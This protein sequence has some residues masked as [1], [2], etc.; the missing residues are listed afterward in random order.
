MADALGL[1][2]VDT[3]AWHRANVPGVNDVWRRQT[4]ANRVAV[5]APAR[6]E[7]L[8]SAKSADDY[9]R[10]RRR[11]DALHQV[12]CGTGAMTRALEVQEALARQHALHHR[13][14]A[15]PDLLIAA[16]AELAGAMVWHY[17]SDYDRIAAVTGQPMEWIVPRG[18]L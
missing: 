1:L 15:I 16:A 3:S 11:L 18:S 7:I 8:Y 2:V 5:T 4:F 10:T 12:P 17:D 9:V 14:V 6:L 13:S